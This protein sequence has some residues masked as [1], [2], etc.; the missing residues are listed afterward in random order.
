M[1]K[2]EI[3]LFITS[4]LGVI[5]MLNVSD[6][7]TLVI[8]SFSA[9]CILYFFL[10]FALFNDIKLRDLF[11]KSAYHTTN[12]KRIGSAIVLGITISTI[13]TGALFR[14]LLLNGGTILNTAGLMALM[15]IL[16][17]NVISYF[18]SRASYYVGTLIRIV[19]YGGLGFILFY[20]PHSTFLTIY[21]RGYPEY[22]ELY[23]KV[24]ANPENIELQ[25]ELE[26]M[27]EEMFNP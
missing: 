3:I 7:S 6:D 24:E 19:I 26:R 4:A 17:V 11:K 15:V 14:F 13:I 5:L 12:A 10:S 21:Y 2:I 1:K 25:Y 22:I 27:E 8:L 18:R 20:T 16:I 9:Q 23:K